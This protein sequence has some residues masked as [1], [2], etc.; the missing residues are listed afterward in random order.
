[1]EFQY[2]VVVLKKVL[3]NMLNTTVGI[4]CIVLLVFVYI[5]TVSICI[6]V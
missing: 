5:N 1:M 6:V 2:L 3:K 4:C